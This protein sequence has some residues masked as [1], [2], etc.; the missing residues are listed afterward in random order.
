M[1]FGSLAS[2]LR[3]AKCPQDFRKTLIFCQ[4]KEMTSKVYTYLSYFQK[5]RIAMYRVSL[6]N[7]TRQHTYMLYRDPSSQLRC[8]VA[9]I[10]FGMVRTLRITIIAQLLYKCSS[11]RVWTSQT[12]NWLLFMEFL[13]LSHSFPRYLPYYMLFN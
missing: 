11:N 4:T 8:I 7:E 12:F 6:S 13:R 9:T 1:T 3:S 5:D 2:G 10:A